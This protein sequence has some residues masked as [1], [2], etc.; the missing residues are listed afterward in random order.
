MPSPGGRN[1]G[2]MLEGACELYGSRL[3]R[4]C[5]LPLVNGRSGHGLSSTSRFRVSCLSWRQ[6]QLLDDLCRFVSVQGQLGQAFERVRPKTGSRAHK[7]KRP[8]R[9]PK[10]EA[11][12]PQRLFFG[13]RT[14][15]AGW[16]SPPVF[17]HMS[18]PSKIG[19]P[20]AAG[21][22]DW[23][24]VGCGLL[25]VRCVLCLQGMPSSGYALQKARPSEG[26]LVRRHT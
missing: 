10:E 8:T 16:S 21:P 23:S 3:C 15:L 25:V 24:L 5:G 7:S 1:C 19:R 11:D 13:S 12:R 9:L 6:V 22:A 4:C 2:R 18:V 20:G 26:M 14:L 17:R